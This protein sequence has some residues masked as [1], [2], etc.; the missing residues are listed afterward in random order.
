METAQARLT[1]LFE[2]PFWVGLFERETAGCYCACKVTFGAEP[3][4]FEVYQ[5]ILDRWNTLKFSPTLAS[6]LP[7]Q[8]RV[9]PKRRQR[10]LQKQASEGIGTKAQQALKLQQEQG[11]AVRQFRARQRRE[12]EQ[13][14][15][16]QLR[17]EKRREKHRGR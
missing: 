16:Y 10:M 8:R 14:R 15:K 1:V 11:K 13:E 2:D 12:A 6:S 3:R 5:Y 4:D 17:Q 9:N 7:D